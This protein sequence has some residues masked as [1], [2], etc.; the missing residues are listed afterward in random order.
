MILDCDESIVSAIKINQHELNRDEYY[1]N[2]IYDNEK[3][4]NH[5]GTT[6]L[7]HDGNAKLQNSEKITED[8]YVLNTEAKLNL[9]N[10]RYYA[11][12]GCFS[13]IYSEFIEDLKHGEWIN[14]HGSSKLVFDTPVVTRWHEAYRSC[15]IVPEMIQKGYAYC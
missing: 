7:L 5:H 11:V 6:F 8:I 14:V 2:N 4:T 1:I 13:F 9:Q 15:G 3:N 12:S 10:K